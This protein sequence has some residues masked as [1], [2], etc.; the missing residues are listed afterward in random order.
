LLLQGILYSWILQTFCA[1]DLLFAIFPQKSKSNAN[2]SKG[3]TG[4]YLISRV[5]LR[6]HDPV[7]GGQGLC[8]RYG[9]RNSFQ[10]DAHKAYQKYGK[11]LYSSMIVYRVYTLSCSASNPP[12]LLTMPC[13][14]RWVSCL[15]SANS[16]CRNLGISPLPRLVTVTQRIE[17]AFCHDMPR[18]NLLAQVGPL[19]AAF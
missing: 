10:K 16:A 19:P 8:Q 11:L 12:H 14:F 5:R 13:S 15:C 2:K 17:E 9:S 1:L 7:T 3:Q 4:E 6:F 18:S